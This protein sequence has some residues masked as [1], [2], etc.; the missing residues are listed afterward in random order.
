[1]FRGTIALLFFLLASSSALAGNKRVALVIGNSA[2]QHTPKLTN[3]KNDA[4]DLA[5][6]LK[7]HG[8]QVIDGF[9]VTKAALERKIEEFA[10][11]LNGAGV[12][13]FFYAGHGL[14]VSGINYLV[15][16]DAQLATASVLELQ[17]VRVDLV[18]RIMEHETNTN[19]L[20]LDACRDNPLA[21]NLARAMGTRSAE[22]GRGLAAVASGGGTLISFSTQPGNVALDGSGRNSPF[23]GALVKHMA[24]SSD[25]LSAILIAVRNDVMKETQRKQ[26]PWEH[27][28]LT[29]RFYFGQAPPAETPTAAPAPVQQISEA[30]RTWAIV[31]STKS[32]GVL[33]DFI[34]R[35]K[36]TIFAKLAQERIDD[37]RKQHLAMA[38]PPKTPPPVKPV[39]SA[40]AA[41]ARCDGVEAVIGSERR[42]LKPKDSFKDCPGCPEMVVVPAGEFTMGSPA[43]EESRQGHESPQHNVRIPKPFAVGK[44]EISFTEWDACVREE[45]CAQVNVNEKGWRGGNLPVIRVSWLEAKAYT[46][47]L[48]KRTRS[49]YRL[50]SEAEW[51]YVAR[52]GTTTTFWWGTSAEDTRANYSRPGSPNR[53]LPVD[54]H[55]ANPF[56]LFNVLGNVAEWIE[57]C[58]HPDY[59][60]APT[61]GGAWLFHT[62][63]VRG[64]RGGAWSTESSHMRAAKRQWYPPTDRARDIGLRIARDFR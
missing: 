55:G 10:A 35:Y 20:F 6:A 26:V 62:C 63:T 4:T 31:Q 30:E 40:V 27:S 9:D 46:A 16:I 54:S 50:L 15:P 22:V 34:A 57:D 36:D 23:A 32:I 25:D 58:W 1:M 45:G 17:T 64:H 52:A 59:Q 49:A 44:F 14:Q 61:D 7:K 8:F 33:E 42:C 60:G 47:W 48:S 56:G 2:Y 13:L 29:E 51:E 28:A 21:R 38:A 53:P 19:I 41:T 24:A 11:A 18:H 39:E 37:L 12:G 5:A 3:P 43:S